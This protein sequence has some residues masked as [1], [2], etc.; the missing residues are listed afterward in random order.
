[1]GYDT[2]LQ[3]EYRLQEEEAV[4]IPD[5]GTTLNYAGVS[6]DSKSAVSRAARSGK[7][8]SEEEIQSI[9]KANRKVFSQNYFEEKSFKAA[10]ETA[11]QRDREGLQIQND[12]IEEQL[13]QAKAANVAPKQP[14]ASQQSKGYQ[15][16]GYQ[17][18]DYNC[19]SYQI[20]DYEI[21]EY[22]SVYD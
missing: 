1:M 8:S 14:G 7:I 2:A 19:G 13:A 17:I 20:G 11:K 10:N 3:N 21:S 12:H 6:D 18:S 22:K 4:A 5:N 16:K 15:T 9:R